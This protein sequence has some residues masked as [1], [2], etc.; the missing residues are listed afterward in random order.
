M[1]LIISKEFGIL[2]DEVFDQVCPGLRV[3][4]RDILH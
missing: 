1:I 4:Y 2:V 3:A